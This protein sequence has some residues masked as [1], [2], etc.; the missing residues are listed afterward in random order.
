VN[1]I[2]RLLT[3]LRYV[4]DLIG[5]EHVGLGID[6]VFDQ[7]ELEDQLHQNPALFAPGT[8]PASP[9]IA[10][11]AMAEIAEGLAR[12]KLSD[13]QIRGILGENW[14]RIAEQIWK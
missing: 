1:L 13:A 4:I 8:D 6:Y 14:L 11:E 2:E 9:T 7:R 12:T 3:Q 10:P 5:P